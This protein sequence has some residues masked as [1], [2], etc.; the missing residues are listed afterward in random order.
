MTEPENSA[1]ATSVAEL[2]IRYGFDLN[3]YPLDRWIDQWLAQYPPA[4][5]YSAVIEALYQGRYKAI[6]VWQILD[7]WRRRGRPVQHFNRDFERIISGRS[8]PLLFSEAMSPG[9]FLPESVLVTTETGIEPST[10]PHRELNP[11]YTNGNAAS[12]PSSAVKHWSIATPPQSQPSSLW[13]AEQ[14]QSLQTEPLLFEHPPAIEPFKP[15][16]EFQLHLPSPQKSR[17]I[18]P[19]P[20]QQFVPISQ[21]PE[22]HGKLKAMAQAI[23]RSNAE[24]TAKAIQAAKQQP[25]PKA[26]E[27]AEK[28]EAEMPSQ[29]DQPR[30][31]QTDS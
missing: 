19:P 28:T 27:T 29:S 17:S 13:T 18:A 23:L 31:D 25:Q 21:P 26:A 6:S 3:G 20:I 24:A 12:A 8:I 2:V 1:I 7:L 11:H 30:S 4:W 15:S 9:M 10:G 5:L 22:L 16:V 14:P